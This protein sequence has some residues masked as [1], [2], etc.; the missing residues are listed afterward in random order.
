MAAPLAGAECGTQRDDVGGQAPR[1]RGEQRQRLSPPAGRGAGAHSQVEVADSER[2]SFGLLECLKGQ[3]DQVC[4]SGPLQV[5]EHLAVF[6]IWGV[7]F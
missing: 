4:S 5:L 1:G 7:L 2:R 6:L 3:A